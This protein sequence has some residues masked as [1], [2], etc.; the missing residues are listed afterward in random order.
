MIKLFFFAVP[1][2]TTVKKQTKRNNIY[3]VVKLYSRAF[4]QGGHNYRITLLQRLRKNNKKIRHPCFQRRF[5]YGYRDMSRLKMHKA[6]RVFIC[7]L[8]MYSKLQKFLCPKNVKP[9]NHAK[10]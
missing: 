5:G 6:P 10:Y 7:L 2:Y 9:E 1:E 3:F 4:L 8:V